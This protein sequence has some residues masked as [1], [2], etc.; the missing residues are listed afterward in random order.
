MDVPNVLREITSKHV[1]KADYQN[2]TEG[3]LEEKVPYETA[4][5]ALK[6]ISGNYMF[7]K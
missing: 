3:L 1:Y 4:I 6:Q 2:L 7:E 5:T